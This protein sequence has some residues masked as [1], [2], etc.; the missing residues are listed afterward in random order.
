MAEPTSP[1]PAGTPDPHQLKGALKSFKKKLKLSRLDK[2]S[3]IIAGPL[4]K[5]SQSGIV[6]VTPPSQFPPEIWQELARQGKLKDEG[7]GTYSLVE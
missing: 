4:S 3:R 6:A 1:P 2:E 5:G 7:G